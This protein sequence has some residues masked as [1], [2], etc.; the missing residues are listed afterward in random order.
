[1][2]NIYAEPYQP[3]SPRAWNS[4]LMV[5]TAVAMMVRSMATR[6]RAMKLQTRM[7]QKR[8]LFG[9][10]RSFSVCGPGGVGESFSTSLAATAGGPSAAPSPPRAPD[11]GDSAKA[12]VPI[13]RPD[14]PPK[15]A[16][17]YR[18]VEAMVAVVSGLRWA[19]AGVGFARLGR[20]VVEC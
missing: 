20:V 2:V 3:I 9:W 13:T 6:K 1:M 18:A 14:C 15:E 7:S 5:G 19:D 12:S 4:S 10:Y 16:A 17:E 8:R 11:E